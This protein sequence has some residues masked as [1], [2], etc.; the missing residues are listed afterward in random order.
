MTDG[1]PTGVTGAVLE[2]VREVLD[3]HPE[4]V[5]G[6]L[7]GSTARGDGG[8]DSDVDVAVYLDHP[9]GLMEAARIEQDLTDRLGS[10]A[11]DVLI[12]NDAPLWLQFRVL[13]E[14]ML[15]FSRDDPRRV[16]FRERTEKMFLDFKPFHD[17]Y[18]A[19]VRER[20]R[21]GRLSRG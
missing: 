19:A 8:Q 1:E 16:R 21:A 3:R 5:F 18:L 11:A 6:Y 20:A 10:R 7:F 17:T 9:A 15:G 2:T 12:L 14:G 13:G 4:V